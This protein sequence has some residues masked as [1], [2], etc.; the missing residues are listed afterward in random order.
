MKINKTLV[1]LLVIF[2]VLV[3]VRAYRGLYM[4]PKPEK[5]TVQETGQKQEEKYIPKETIEKEVIKEESEV[6]EEVAAGSVWETD[7]NTL[8]EGMQVSGYTAEL[9]RILEIDA[10][11]VTGKCRTWLEQNGYTGVTGLAFC[12]GVQITLSEQKYSV[13]C[14]LIYADGQGNGIQPQATVLVMD[15]YKNRGLY[16]FHS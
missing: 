9:E 1:L 7:R 5:Q 15:Y 11:T 3:G 14:Q 10:E 8:F 16:Q 12:D 6:Q 4:S 2:V 13:E